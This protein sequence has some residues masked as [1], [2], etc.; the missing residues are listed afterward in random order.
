MSDREDP[1]APFLVLMVARGRSSLDSQTAQ[2]VGMPQT[3]ANV[4]CERSS[5]MERQRA[6]SS[7]MRKTGAI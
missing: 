4:L 6:M 3:C 7:S 5:T 1:A 2:R